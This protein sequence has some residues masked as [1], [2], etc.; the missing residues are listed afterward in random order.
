[1]ERETPGG[2]FNNL[3]DQMLYR[4]SIDGWCNESSGSAEAPTGWFARISISLAE[5]PEIV[6]A[7]DE[8]MAG[9]GFVETESLIGHHLIIEDGSGPLRVIAYDSEPELRSDY[10][11]LTTAYDEWTGGRS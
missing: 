6:D 3:T 11:A 7:F 1:M 4:L 8:P 10:R 2:K 9:A 5:L